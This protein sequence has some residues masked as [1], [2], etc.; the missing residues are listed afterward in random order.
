MVSLHQRRGCNCIIHKR[1]GLLERYRSIHSAYAY[2]N[3][4]IIHSVENYIHSDREA[5]GSIPVHRLSCPHL[6]RCPVVSCFIVLALL[7]FISCRVFLGLSVLFSFVSICHV[8]SSLSC[9]SCLL[10]LLLSFSLCIV[11]ICLSCLVLPCLFLPN[12]ITA[13]SIWTVQFLNRTLLDFHMF[14]NIV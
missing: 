2:C 13:H 3:D 7:S 1:N 10:F 5:L 12:P 9:A 6:R 4:K 8:L 14:L 11:L